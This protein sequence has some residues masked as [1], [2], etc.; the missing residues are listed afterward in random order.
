MT[1][2][3]AATLRASDSLSVLRGGTRAMVD[4]LQRRRDEVGTSYIAVNVAFMHALAPAVEAL[5]GT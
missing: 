2:V 3:D 5:T 1:G 4:E